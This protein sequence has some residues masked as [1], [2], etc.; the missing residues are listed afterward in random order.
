MVAVHASAAEVA[1]IGVFEGLSPE[2]LEDCA[3]HA[4]RR[5][6]PTRRTVFRQGERCERFQALLSGCIRISQSG[7]DGGLALMRFVGPGEPFGFFGMLVDGCYPAEA[8]TLATSIELSWSKGDFHQLI[9][10]HASVVVG[11]TTLAARRLADLQERLREITTLRA[12]ERIANALVRLARAQ[13]RQL[14]DGG[15]EI[16][17]PVTR[18]DVAALSATS[19]YTASRVLSRWERDGLIRSAAKQVTINSVSNLRHIGMPL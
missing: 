8:S 17:W 18:K 7:R 5:V 11:L 16:A 3:A 12:E 14:A 19:L 4:V 6:L 1:A 13:G 10:R 2:A 15:L 9:G